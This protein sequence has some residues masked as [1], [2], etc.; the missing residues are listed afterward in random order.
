MMDLLWLFL[1]FAKISIIGFGGG[2]GIMSI[3][4]TEVAKFSVT[5][6]Q[7]GDLIALELIV[8]GPIAINAATYVGFLAQG[9]P[10]SVI[11]TLGI[12]L[13]CLTLS[14]I[15]YRF[16]DRFRSNALLQSF[17]SGV[18]PAAVGL[19]AAAAIIVGRDVIGGLQIRGV[20]ASA[21]IMLL[22]LVGSA[23]FKVNP[24]LLTVLSGVAGA[25][26]VR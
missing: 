21:A 26:F 16:I 20:A 11:A 15:V 14:Y 3:M 10:G 17:L 7:F 8:P 24:I 4:L 22:V 5:A 23:K 18:K 25:F 13:P 6:A 2:Y 12:S 9:I 1:S 19:I